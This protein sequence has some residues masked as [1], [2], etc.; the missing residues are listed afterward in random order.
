MSTRGLLGFVAD[1]LETCTYNHGDSYPSGLGVEVLR[2]ARRCEGTNFHRFK[3]AAA[4]LTQV[5]EDGRKPTR[6]EVVKLAG[7]AD[8]KVSTG[9][10]HAEWYV[11]LRDTQGDPEA[12]LS[13]GY[14]IHDP[15]WPR[16]SLFCEWGYVLDFDSQT[17]EVYKGFNQ[18]PPTAGRWTGVTEASFHQYY[19]INMIA[20][21]TFDNLPDDDTFCLLEETHG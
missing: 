11:L 5:S 9:D 12:I 6:D 16:D 13:C 7:H 1:G 4:S 8:T 17:L 15:D 10:A 3:S 2:F 14:A 18:A 19:A 20:S 21:Y